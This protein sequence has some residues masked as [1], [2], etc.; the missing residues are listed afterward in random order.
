MPVS[1]GA[2]Q[3][4]N[5]ANPIGL[6]ADCHRRIERFL[7]V[8]ISVAAEAKEGSLGGENRHALQTA[9]SYFHDAAP[10]HTA[11]EEED[12]FP[13][14]RRVERP[15]IEG[16]IMGVSRLESEH[17]IATAWHQQVH[18]IGERWL[19]QNYLLPHEAVE[20]K[21]VLTSLTEMYRGHIALEENQIFPMAQ[22][23][24]SA[25]EK[26]AIGR[27]MAARRGVRFVV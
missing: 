13:R 26:E 19:R 24:L 16:I 21:K 18:E 27:R 15:D 10:M 6:L 5:F 2:T 1:I 4:S 23:T 14:L 9:L 25:S 7:E 20:L 11:D 8:L 17:S 12:L 3:E 22:E